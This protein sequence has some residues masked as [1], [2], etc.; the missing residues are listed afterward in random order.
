[1]KK[2][3]ALILVLSFFV[4]PVHAETIDTSWYELTDNVLT[5]RLA[6]DTEADQK[7]AFTVT[8]A[9]I[10][11]S[12]TFETVTETDTPYFAASFANFTG[13]AGEAEV[14][15]YK[16]TWDDMVV[17]VASVEV[18]AGENG[19]LTVKNASR[20]TVEEDFGIYINPF[21]YNLFMVN[22]VYSPDASGVLCAEGTFGEMDPVMTDEGLQLIG[23]DESRPL[24]V[25]FADGCVFYVPA[26]LNNPDVNVEVED[27]YAWYCAACE[28]LG[29]RYSFYATFEMN[30]DGA[31]TRLEYFYIP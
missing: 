20:V 21:S 7:W 30:T 29:F 1:M 10:V 8:D 15:L 5:V 13:T 26:D 4:L 17:E 6:V 9:G 16:Y 27:F 23:F 12:V 24:T 2:L 28:L 18:E 25:A 14:L 31:F 11:D 22:D 3:L 19:A